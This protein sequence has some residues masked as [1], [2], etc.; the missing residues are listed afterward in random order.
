MPNKSWT[1]N[2]SFEG[3]SMQSRPR[4]APEGYYVG[5]I[6]DTF[7]DDERPNRVNFHVEITE[8]DYKG[9]VCRDSMMIPGTYQGKDNTYYWGQLLLSVGTP[10]ENLTGNVPIPDGAKLIGLTTTVFFKPGNREEG[11]WNRMRFLEKSK[12]AQDKKVFE[13]SGSAISGK[14]PVANAIPTPTPAVTPSIP[15]NGGIPQA[16]SGYAPQ[17]SGGSNILDLLNASN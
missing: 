10:V 15:T 11:T 16:T 4:V 14:S 2:L 1:A 6:V 8:G 13:A 7:V 5:K 12:W 3:V 9:F 17:A